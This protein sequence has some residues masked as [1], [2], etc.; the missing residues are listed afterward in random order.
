MENKLTD[1]QAKKG[2]GKGLASLLPNA[3]AMNV[4]PAPPATPR[5]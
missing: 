1:N 5:F 4:P 2:L 3:R